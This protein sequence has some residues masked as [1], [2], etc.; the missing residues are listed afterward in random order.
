V[1]AIQAE[2]AGAAASSDRFA[3]ADAVFTACRATVGLSEA[4]CSLL[5]RDVRASP[6]GNA[7]KRAG[8]VCSRLGLCSAALIGDA[9]CAVAVSNTTSG[10]LDLC[11]VEGISSGTRVAGI[12]AN[13]SEL[14]R[15]RSAVQRVRHAAS[16]VDTHSQQWRA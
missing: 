2:V 12:R 11:S 16:P 9:S 14:L 3:V 6:G 1:S 10:A 8:L 15:G 4:A 7:G 5:R 13:T